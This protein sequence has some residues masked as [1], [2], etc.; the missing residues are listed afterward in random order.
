MWGSPLQA[1][2]SGATGRAGPVTTRPP[3]PGR[4]R[5]RC[6][7]AGRPGSA[8][9]SGRIRLPRLPGLLE[10][11][12]PG[13][14]RSRSAT[15]LHPRP[16]RAPRSRVQFAARSGPL[17]AGAPTTASRLARKPS[18]GQDRAGLGGPGRARPA[19][20][21]AAGP[22]PRRGLG[23]SSAAAAHGLGSRRGPGP[24]SGDGL[25]GVRTG[26]RWPVA[27]P[28]TPP[29]ASAPT[30]MATTRPRRRRAG[31]A[32]PG[33]RR[34]AEPGP[35]PGTR[36]GPPPGRR[37]PRRA[38][39]T[40]AGSW[41]TA[42]YP[43]GACGGGSA[44]V[45]SS[46]T[47]SSSRAS[48][49]ASRLACGRRIS[50]EEAS[51]VPI[52]LH[53]PPHAAVVAQPFG[54]AAQP[55]V[56]EHPDRPRP[57]AHDLRRSRPQPGHHPQQ[58]RLGLVGREGRHL[59][60]RRP[61][62]EPSRASAAG[63]SGAACSMRPFAGRSSVAR[64]AAR[65]RRSSTSCR[66]M[67]NTQARKAGSLPTK[68]VETAD[69]PEPGLSRPGPRPPPGTPPR[70]TAAGGAAGR[71]RASRTRPRR[72]GRRRRARPGSRDRSSPSTAPDRH[73]G[74]RTSAHPQS[75]GPRPAG[76]IDTA[77]NPMI[78]RR[79]QAS[80]RLARSNPARQK[81]V[82]RRRR[83]TPRRNP[84]DLGVLVTCPGAPV[85]AG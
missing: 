35:R 2:G 20:R 33:R 73:S 76:G 22:P 82:N 47:V 79:R 54:Q 13:Q 39:A 67:V 77:D 83:V 70:S 31:E 23:S 19:A 1:R 80:L 69:H 11:L 43:A 72:P 75:G 68:P 62:R 18:G 51:S 4:H 58:D 9:R 60:Q 30:T 78:P 37:A 84:G 32:G 44:P 28:A 61:G 40:A 14:V 3:G 41:A 81:G 6:W 56:G 57:L 10:L 71:A 46:S 52:A 8:R 49:W 66:A 38:A 16:P 15:S 85:P 7:P 45:S 55:T 24:G 63:S 50:A 29:V 36:P 27:A 59:G 74:T 17:P 53:H 48:G 25:G 42:A 5:R 34:P 65:R 12:V 64:R 26:P 21:D